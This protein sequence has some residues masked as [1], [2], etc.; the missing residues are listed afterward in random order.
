MFPD[1]TGLSTKRPKYESPT[2]KLGA[3]VEQ[4][5]PNAKSSTTD[6]EI[7]IEDDEMS[8]EFTVT[9]PGTGEYGTFFIDTRTEELGI[10]GIGCEVFV[11]LKISSRKGED[12]ELIK[13]DMLYPHLGKCSLSA[14]Q[15]G[16]FVLT[17]ISAMAHLMGKTRIEL[18]DSARMASM[19]DELHYGGVYSLTC[20]LRLHRGFGYYEKRGFF[21][22]DETDAEKAKA[23]QTLELEWTEAV[24]ATPL[25]RLHDAL[26]LLTKKAGNEVLRKPKMRDHLEQTVNAVIEGHAAS[27][28][29]MS[30]RQLALRAQL[31]AYGRHALCLLLSMRQKRTRLCKRIYYNSDG[32]PFHLA[33]KAGPNGEPVV[34]EEYVSLDF[35]VTGVHQSRK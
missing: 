2:V 18:V 28:H 30:T 25:E 24:V 19:P 13:V 6:S 11:D 12:K 21:T 31:P 23:Q 34:Y 5:L 26:L 14:D 7:H 3:F 1:L 35:D 10:S 27:D 15:P 20:A 17:T 4:Y 22:F 32:R 33:C 29:H 8:I 9:D 16:D